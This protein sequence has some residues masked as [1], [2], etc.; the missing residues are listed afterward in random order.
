M[1]I[2]ARIDAGERVRLA[3]MAAFIAALYAIGIGLTAIYAPHHA[4][5][6]GSAT[7][8]FTLGL[9]HAFD[10]DHIAA[11][12]NTTRQLRQQ[13]RRPVGVG[14]FFSLGHATVVLVLTFVVALV[15]HAVPDISDSTGFIG[16]SVSGTFLWVIGILNLAA[17]LDVIRVARQMRRGDV[18]EQQLEQMLVPRGLLTRLGLDRL[19]RLV[20]RSWQMFPIGLLFGLGFDTATEVALLALGAGAAAA[21]LPLLAVLA[22]PAL[23]AAGMATMDTLD[24]VLMGH[25]YDW[26]LRR[27]ARKLL[28]NLTITSLSVTVA[29]GVGTIQLAN[30]AIQALDLKGGLWDTIANLDFQV[31]GYIMAGLFVTT[32]L[33]ALLLWRALDLE[34]RLT[35]PPPGAV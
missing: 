34:A 30:V 6:F 21:G 14:F 17:L 32:W 27:P 13:G 33:I 4:G 16:A 35:P 5:L 23:F 7:L 25:A 8:A 19:M 11:I 26:A 28:Y 12:D 24:G 9:R 3:T 1:S 2:L 20:A 22:L 10:A 18:D 29:L 15:T 31:I